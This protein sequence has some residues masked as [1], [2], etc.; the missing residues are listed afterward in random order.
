VLTEKGVGQMTA[1]DRYVRLESDA[2]WR[3]GTDAQRR[4]VTIS[5]G[6]ATLVI[7]DGAGRPLAHWS[8]PALIRQNPSESPAIYAPDDEAS[9]VLEIADTTM[10]EAIEEVQKSLAKTR[11]HPGTLRHWLTAGLIAVTLSLAI[12]WLPGALTRQTLALVPLPKRMEI[13]A[14]MLGHMQAQT[15][16]VCRS[17][18]ATAAAE[19]L[20]QRL[21]GT[22]TATRIVVV[23][24]LAQ[25]AVALSGGLIALDYGVLQASDDPAAVAGFVLAS[26]AAVIHMDPLEALLKRA[27]LGVTF[28]LLTTGE[29][30]DDILRSSAQAL[31]DAPAPIP[32]AEILRNILAAASI[33]QGPYLAAADARTGN[34]PELGD[35]P[36]EG[37]VVPQILTDSAW[38]SLQNVC[39]V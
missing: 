17:A 3:A 38:V 22:D 20:A 4:D 25:G 31:L 33:P 2:L 28:R 39:N 18:Q 35:D 23:P 37:Q 30:P 6:D 10:I 34:M 16:A 32:D 13:G 9:E 12:F 26:R 1:L 14:A 21:F 15:G 36:M 5:F 29:I 19:Q 8:L 27:G 11:S 7:A 24:K